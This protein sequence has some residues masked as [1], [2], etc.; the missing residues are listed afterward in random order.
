MR[1]PIVE[2]EGEPLELGE[3]HLRL[4]DKLGLIPPIPE[5]LY[6]AAEESH[7]GL[8]QGPDGVCHDR[9]ES[10]EE[11]AVYFGQDAGQGDGLGS[12]GS[13]VGNAA[14]RAQILP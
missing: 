7:A 11:H 1:R 12:S 14:G 6:Q 8:C 4:A 9:T 5:S 13:P 10:H 3:I 2:P